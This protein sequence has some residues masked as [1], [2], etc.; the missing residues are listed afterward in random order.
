MIDRKQQKQ[1]RKLINS[2]RDQTI[3]FLRAQTAHNASCTTID[4]AGRYRIN[5]IVTD[6]GD[7]E[8]K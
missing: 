5:L 2:A 6:T 3:D 4:R 1:I 7:K 8:I